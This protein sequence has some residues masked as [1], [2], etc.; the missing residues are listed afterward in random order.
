M[1][2]GLD[3][4]WSFPPIRANRSVAQIEEEMRNGMTRAQ[5]QQ[6]DRLMFEGYAPLPA[7]GATL[8]VPTMSEDMEPMMPDP[9]WFFGGSQ[10]TVKKEPEVKPDIVA[11]LL[12][13]DELPDGYLELAKR[14]G[15]VNLAM[16]RVELLRTFQKLEIPVY[17]YHKVRKF[18][19]WAT[20]EEARKQ[21]M[22]LLSSS[23]EGLA[24]YWA[25][26]RDGDQQMLNHEILPFTFRGPV[27][28]DK[29]IPEK[30]LRKVDSLLSDFQWPEKLTFG[31]TDYAVVKPDPFL[32]VMLKGSTELFVI[33]H[34]DEPYFKL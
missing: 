8:R 5:A 12:A 21:G 24:W 25:P 32:A 22:S 15:V 31:V 34:W 30:A 14:V 26:L 9:S 23:R 29:A 20:R 28:Y 18:M 33:D 11:E 10:V 19:A 6:M 16:L 13:T 2:M 4:L 1:A 17:P 7:K 3:K 27:V